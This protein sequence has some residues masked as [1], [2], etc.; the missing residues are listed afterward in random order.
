M[1]AFNRRFINLVDLMDIDGT[2]HIAFEAGVRRPDG[3]SSEAPGAGHLHDILY[4]SAVQMIP[5]HR[6]PSPLHSSTTSGPASLMNF[7]PARALA[8]NQRSS[9]IRTSIS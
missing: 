6:N 8:R 2:P 5:A 9:L 4:V 7:G 3:S 1:S